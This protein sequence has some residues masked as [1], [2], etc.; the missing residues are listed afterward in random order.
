MKP[1]SSDA[2]NVHTFVRVLRLIPNSP[3]NERDQIVEECCGIAPE[4]L[5]NRLSAALS[6]VFRGISPL[7]YWIKQIKNIMQNID[8]A[9]DPKT[10]DGIHSE[11]TQADIDAEIITKVEKGSYWY[12]TILLSCV[13]YRCYDNVPYEEYPWLDSLV[14]RA[15]ESDDDS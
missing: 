6:R 7:P 4:L 15:A 3:R 1:K 12:L 8:Q 9:L 14:L 5:Y 11:A 13:D 10:D 2:F